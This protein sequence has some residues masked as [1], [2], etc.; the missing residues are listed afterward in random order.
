MESSHWYIWKTKYQC[1]YRRKKTKTL[2]HQANRKEEL[3]RSQERY[4]KNRSEEK[5]KMTNWYRENKVKRAKTMAYWRLKNKDLLSFY[6]KNKKEK[7][8]NYRLACNLRSR[9]SNAIRNGT[10]AGSAV[11]N[12]GCT[13][14]ELKKYL[15]SKFEPW[16][17]WSNYGQSGN[18]WNIDH[19]RPLNSF[20]LS[21]PDDL[22]QA[23]HYTNLQPLS[24][25]KN[26]SKGDRYV[27]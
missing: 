1:K 25:S 14:E 12:L 15:E 26:F 20:D 5:V 18:V 2:Y 16:M 24:A 22:K 19:I 11:Q 17:D 13:I 6:Y 10:Q 3:I 23:C 7:D 8:L 9:L 4:A 21:N 27:N